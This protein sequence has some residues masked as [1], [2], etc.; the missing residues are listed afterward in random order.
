MSQCKYNIS[1][2]DEQILLKLAQLA[3][4]PRGKGVK[5]STFEIRRSKVMVIQH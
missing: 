4:G 2:I 5:R 3:C 1:Q